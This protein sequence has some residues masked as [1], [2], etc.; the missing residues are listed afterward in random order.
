MSK[1]A[2][3]AAVLPVDGVEQATAE[4][5]TFPAL[6]P[7]TGE[8]LWQVPDAGEADVVTAATAARRA[9]LE[10]GERVA[11]HALERAG[12][13][14][15]EAELAVL[16]ARPVDALLQLATERNARLIVVGSYGDSPLKGA[17]LGSTPH[18]LLHLADRP[19][20]AVPAAEASVEA[21]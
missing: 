1:H 13:A 9:L 10:L 8:T 5:R 11:R 14:G 4:G 19:V 6:D 7:S 16:G 21:V 18:K 17:I 2:R 20:L 3:S 15:C 12:A